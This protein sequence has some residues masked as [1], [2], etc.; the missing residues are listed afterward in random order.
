MNDN[1]NSSNSKDIND[2]NILKQINKPK[3]IS[4]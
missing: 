1:N 4:K 3:T 2:S